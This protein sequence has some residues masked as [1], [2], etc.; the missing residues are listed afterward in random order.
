MNLYHIKL[1]DNQKDALERL[2]NMG[3][4]WNK[5]ELSEAW[6]QLRE[7]VRE[8]SCTVAIINALQDAKCNCSKATDPASKYDPN[9]KFRK[10]DKVRPVERYGRMP[11]DGAPVNFICE[12]VEDELKNGTVAI[13]ARGNC[14]SVQFRVTALYLELVTPV[15]EMEP[16]SVVDAHTHWDVA[17][18]DMKCVVTYSKLHH[19]HAK[20]AAEDECDR[21]NAEWR[22]ETK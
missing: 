7:Q 13:R 14:G 3:I 19:P 10:G 2:F 21:L 20:A 12:V 16:Y 5:T 6:E 18:K 11:E 22:K 17:D 8:A 9:R 1:T 4:V 15:E